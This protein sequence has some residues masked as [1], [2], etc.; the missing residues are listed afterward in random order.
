MPLRTPPILVVIPAVSS[1]PGRPRPS[2]VLRQRPR[3]RGCRQGSSCA[4]VSRGPARRGARSGWRC[5]THDQQ[6]ATEVFPWPR[7]SRRERAV[8]AVAGGANRPCQTRDR[9]QKEDEPLGLRKPRRRPPSVS[10]RDGRVASTPTARSGSPAPAYARRATAIRDRCAS[11]ATGTSSGGART[12][13]EPGP[14]RAGA[15]DRAGG[16]G[17][18]DAARAGVAE[19]LVRRRARGRV[20]FHGW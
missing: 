14:V 16:G 5:S 2:A 6:G 7:R 9:I 3:V 10:A 18:T 11:G 15:G 13:G 17:A 4:Y 20:T 8:G 12:V 19:S 1:P